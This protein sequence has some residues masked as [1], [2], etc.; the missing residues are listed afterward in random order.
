M[1]VK[2]SPKARF[3]IKQ[4]RSA[5]NWL[6]IGLIASV[7]LLLIGVTY[8]LGQEMAVRGIFEKDREHAALLIRLE[9]AE[10]KYAELNTKVLVYEQDSAINRQA[11]EQVRVENKR[12]QEKINEL[13]EAVAF[14]RGVMNPSK[15]VRGL[16]IAKLSLNSTNDD[17]RYRYK[18]VLTQVA[19]NSR[20][21]E[22]KAYF[23]VIGVQDG[24]IKSLSYQQLISD[25]EN[26]TIKFRFRYFQ[27]FEGVISLPEGFIP[28]RVEMIAESKGKGAV[29][30]EESFNWSIEEG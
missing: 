13:E 4:D 9:D 2:G 19:E 24:M 6:L 27:D 22:G 5:R 20:D 15:N 11:N 1:T 10:K 26:S 14:Y 23:N 17:R 3:V 28:E 25:Q 29:R 21:I 16:R 30:L 8:R 12:L 7:F 18:F